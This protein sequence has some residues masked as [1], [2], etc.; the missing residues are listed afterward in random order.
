MTGFDFGNTGIDASDL[1]FQYLIM[2][3]QAKSYYL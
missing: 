3:L 1:Y 2:S